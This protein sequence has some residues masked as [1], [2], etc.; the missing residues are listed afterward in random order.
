M[1]DS[2][3]NLI[4]STALQALFSSGK[5]SFPVTSLQLLTRFILPARSTATTPR[6]KLTDL[7]RFESVLEDLSRTWEGGSIVLS[8][9][10]GSL[11]VVEVRLMVS[12]SE[13]VNPRKRKR[14]VDED[15]DSAAGDE[16]AEEQEVW[17]RMPVVK[18]ASTLD[19]LSDEMKE[20]Y[21]ILQKGTAK[22]RLLAEQVGLFRCRMCG[23]GCLSLFAAPICERDVRADLF[24][25]HQRGLC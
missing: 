24:A 23:C 1:S 16:N 15:A 5:V 10:G 8:R 4:A 19:N 22:G 7:P 14:E 3:L 6:F 9:D 17:D 13:G 25:Y 21:A 2:E 18:S 11:A 12:G 20:V